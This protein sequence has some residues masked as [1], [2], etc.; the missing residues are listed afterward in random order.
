MASQILLLFACDRMKYTLWQHLAVMGMVRQ[1]S[2]KHL[3]S[4]GAELQRAVTRSR[5][6]RDSGTTSDAANF[7]SASCIA[8][9]L[10]V[11]F[12][13]SIV[14]RTACWQGRNDPPLDEGHAPFQVSAVHLSAF[15]AVPTGN[16]RRHAPNLLQRALSVDTYPREP[17]KFR[18]PKPE[19]QRTGCLCLPCG[20]PALPRLRP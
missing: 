1:G 8:L 19:K 15:Q 12:L 10:A 7:R 13:C 4:K 18:C 16:L 6:L 20:P 2:A 9:R 11:C 3:K 5:P 17:K 14:S